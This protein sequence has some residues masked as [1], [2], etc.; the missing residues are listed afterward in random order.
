MKSSK[1]L[2]KE[3]RRRHEVA[4][5][6][7]WDQTEE[8]LLAE[9]LHNCLRWRE[10]GTLTAEYRAPL[11][12]LLRQQ[13][14]AMHDRLLQALQTHVGE[15]TQTY[16]Q[17]MHPE[18]NNPTPHSSNWQ[19]WLL[20]DLLGSRNQGGIRDV[21][22]LASVFA[23]STNG[24]TEKAASDAHWIAVAEQFAERT[25]RATTDDLAA[26]AEEIAT[27]LRAA[28]RRK[29]SVP[30]SSAKNKAR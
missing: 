6:A 8:T 21:L 25:Q 24:N 1:G 29:L 26:R 4:G 27:T 16:R 5:S 30:S 28:R 22:S 7:V 23:I 11:G 17:R 3:K 18:R 19:E 12:R 20:T 2:G 15:Y 9:R 13:P 14:A 10:V